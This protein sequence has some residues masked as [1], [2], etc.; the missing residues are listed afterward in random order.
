MSQKAE[1]GRAKTVLVFGN[2]DA[3]KAVITTLIAQCR[4]AGPFSDVSFEGDVRFNK[5][6]SKHIRTTIYPTIEE[7]CRS[8]GLEAGRFELRGVNLGA[9]AAM[10]VGVDISGFSADL[11]IFMAMLSARLQIPIP[12]DTVL[13]GHIAASHGEIRLVRNIPVK[14]VASIA[15][16]TVNRFICPSLDAD[17]SIQELAKMDYATIHAAMEQHRGQID[18]RVAKDIAE[19]VDLV[20][21]EHAIVQGA[22]ASGYIDRRF[23]RHYDTRPTVEVARSLGRHMHKRFFALTEHMLSVGDIGPAKDLIG[24]WVAHHV[25]R[26]RYPRH[27]GRRLHRLIQSTPP[28]IQRA[29]HGTLLSV[30]SCIDLSRYAMEGDHDDVLSLYSTLVWRGNNGSRPQF[31]QNERQPAARGSSSTLDIVIFEIQPESLATNIGL[32]IDAARGSFIVDSA[33]VDSYRELLHLVSAFYLHVLRHTE[34][35]EG[36]DATVD[37]AGPEALALLERSFARMGGVAAARAESMIGTHGGVRFVLDRMTDQY[38]QERQGDHVRHVLATAIDPLDWSAKVE[39]MK[40]FL[41][42]FPDAI[43]RELKG[44]SP[45]RFAGKHELIVRTL[46]NSMSEVKQVLRSL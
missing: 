17:L 5:S 7:I 6:T 35:I 24:D 9:A 19:V 36:G 1:I 3:H 13:T 14:L 18:I 40:G 12:S 23:P 28:S 26:R 31:L 20:L 32:P 11:S 22:I 10:D 38:K 41:A 44:E 4:S 15:E 34:R 33:V 29:L 27:F 42:A 37:A 46:V 16:E 39:F 43:P 30:G 8:L 2:D 25:R 21:S 45:E